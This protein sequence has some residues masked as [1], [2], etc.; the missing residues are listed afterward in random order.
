MMSHDS[1]VAPPTPTADAFGGPCRDHSTMG[2]ARRRSR[3]GA[4]CPVCRMAATQSQISSGCAPDS[5]GRRRIRHSN[6]NRTCGAQLE[7][8]VVNAARD[9]DVD[10]DESPLA[11][12]S[13]PSSTAQ[14]HCRK[15]RLE[16]AS[17][18]ALGYCVVFA[19][20]FVGLLV[21]STVTN[22]VQQGQSTA[23]VARSL[24]NGTLSLWLTDDI[25]PALEN[26]TCGNFHAHNDTCYF[27]KHAP[28]CAV[29]GGF[30]NYLELPYCIFN[31]EPPAI[32]LLL[33]WLVF[34]FIALGVTAEDYFCPALSV[35]SD[36]LKLSHNVAGVT[37]LAFGNGAPDIFSVYSSINNAKNGV[38]LAVGALFGAGTF[39]TTVVVGTVSFYYPFALTR[40]PFLRDVSTY[41][42]ATTWTYVV[43]WRQEITTAQAIG[44]CAVYIVYVLV[45]IVG[46]HIYQSRKKRRMDPIAEKKR[47]ARK[48]ELREHPQ[49]GS[50]RHPHS[51]AEA[52]DVAE[53]IGIV[54][55]LGHD[56]QA[57]HHTGATARVGMNGH[58]HA[59]ARAHERSGGSGDESDDDE[60]L[61]ARIVETD[62][63][64]EHTAVT[65][66]VV[67]AGGVRE[68]ELT[69][70]GDEE[71]LLSSRTDLEPPPPAWTQFFRAIVPFTKDDF[72]EA[73]IIGK[74][75]IVLSIPVTIALTITTPVVD[76]DEE[77][78]RWVQY[79]TML[80]CVV[81]PVFGIFGT[82]FGDVTI[83]GVYPVWLLG[84]MVGGVIAL[85][86]WTTTRA[87][88]PPRFHAVF[89]F[90]G[91]L[92]A[93]IWIYIVANEIVNL[94]QTLG[95]MF[96][97]SDAILGL[98][99]LAWGNSIGDFVSN[100]TVARQGY[101]RMAVG[102]AFGGP[103][104]NMLLGIG[105]SCTI[106]CLRND[107][108]FP[109]KDQPSHQL[110]VSG[111]FLLLSLLSSMV[112]IPLCRFHASRKYG[113]YLWVLYLCYLASALA[114][115]F[116]G[117]S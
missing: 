96:G 69:G 63:D 55:A 10:G 88:R 15:H 14:K 38:Q 62:S 114:L 35:I 52:F 112:I 37:F 102:A 1:A 21:L 111:G 11:M 51:L 103:A 4:G 24:D 46:R 18:K 61:D 32:V 101:P 28:D 74:A 50:H 115:E 48:E 108:H 85:V 77:D 12:K 66:A 23:R 73:S 45:V 8:N 117:P 79:L 68:D 90:V 5:R 3:E 6:T 47:E 116:T 82:G 59:R 13:W 29:D 41:L 94:L 100:M 75:Y 67:A 16:R 60:M 27:V 93:V 25:P 22:R 53:S 56:I 43:L 80:Q 106:A 99:V 7:G 64:V 95:R 57:S 105:I 70:Y 36:T 110:A 76:F 17:R 39:V 9:P 2:S 71:P 26:A 34:L 20:V 81:A 58:E 98:T 107:G 72:M 30:I 91:F 65:A 113:V 83:G 49:H 19:C 97:I 40:R 44:F 84:M 92:V 33:L 89:G 42:I 54:A 86:I 109:V 104:L 31:T 78:E 87:S